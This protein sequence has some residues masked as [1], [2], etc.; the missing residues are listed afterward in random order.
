LINFIFR[1]LVALWRWIKSFWSKPV[2]TN[3]PV[4]V[5]PASQVPEAQ[6]LVLDLL[7]LEQ[8]ATEIQDP[9]SSNIADNFY[10]YYWNGNQNCH[11]MSEVMQKLKNGDMEFVK[12]EILQHSTKG[13]DW[14]FAPNPRGRL[15]NTGNGG[16]LC[17]EYK[18]RMRDLLDPIKSSRAMRHNFYIVF[19]LLVNMSIDQQVFYSVRVDK[20]YCAA[21]RFYQLQDY[22]EYQNWLN[23]TALPGFE[24]YMKKQGKNSNYLSENGNSMSRED[25]LQFVKADLDSK[26]A[27][28][29]SK[30][31]AGAVKSH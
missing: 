30:T 2:V 14:F 12:K 21:F 18:N 20:F 4:G 13:I 22:P 24:E 3:P 19:R 26:I 25:F 9:V 31:K 27:D 5:K 6:K 29:D 23:S 15:F 11:G 10:N 7:S 8:L 28:H 1:Q 17:S 16:D